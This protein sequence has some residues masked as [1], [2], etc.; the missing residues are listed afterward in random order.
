MLGLNPRLMAAESLTGLAKVSSLAMLAAL[1]FALSIYTPT[2]IT[3]VRHAETMANATGR[4]TAKNLNAFSEKGKA[5]VASITQIL[6]KEP[7]FDRILVSPSPRALRT[8]APYLKSSGQRAIVWPLL[9][10]C[11]TGHRPKGAHAT[12][13]KFGPKVDIP[14]DLR[15]LFIVEPGHD[16]FPDSPNYNAGLAQVAACVKELGERYS[17][18]RVLILGHSAHGG[19]FIHSLTGKWIE[20]KNAKEIQFSVP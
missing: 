12:S 7:R 13:F 10:E 16:R 11:C 17:S 15:G 8:I 4:Y 3:F 19:Q 20:V 14:S 9:Y 6:L 2:E 5:Q 18:G 1:V